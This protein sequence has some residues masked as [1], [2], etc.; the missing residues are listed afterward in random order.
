MIPARSINFFTYGNGKQVIANHFNDG[1]E[2]AAVHLSAAAL[3]GITTSSFTN[4]IWVVKTRMQ[5]S[6]AHSMPFSSSWEC[7]RT[8][9][10]ESGI[11]GLYKGLSASYLGVSEGIIQWT[12]YEQ[13]KRLS[14]KAEG[15]PLEWMG[16]LGAAGGAKTIASLI[17]YPHEVCPE[18][19]PV[20][21]G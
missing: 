14:K 3:A 12:L 10:H 5:L 7:V 20:Q 1:V 8:I 4:P 17:T 19:F 18:A 2:T 13:L 21:K 9:L 6:A 16:M 11:R 15:S